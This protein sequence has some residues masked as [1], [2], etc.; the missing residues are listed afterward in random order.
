MTETKKRPG[1][2]IFAAVLMF[3]IGA[4]GI[5]NA[6]SAFTN[7]AWL[8]E[9]PSFMGESTVNNQFWWGV[10]ESV[11]G[12]AF[13]IAGYSILKGGRFGFY[14]GIAFSI[15]NSAKWFISLFW[16]PFPAIAGIAISVLVMWALANNEDYFE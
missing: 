7:A 9:I 5:V 15:L 13:L 2:V 11:M 14:W 16:Q 8:A 6:I 12:L 1:A 10:I 3:L 4:V